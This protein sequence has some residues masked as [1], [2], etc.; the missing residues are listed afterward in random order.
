VFA[1]EGLRTRRWLHDKRHRSAD[2]F[3]RRPWR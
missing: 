2:F 1:A 3:T